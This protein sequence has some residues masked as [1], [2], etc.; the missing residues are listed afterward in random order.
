MKKLEFKQSNMVL[1]ITLLK[2]EFN[3]K[4]LVRAIQYAIERKKVEGL[5]IY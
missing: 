3:G 5:F 2:G 4:L 1:R